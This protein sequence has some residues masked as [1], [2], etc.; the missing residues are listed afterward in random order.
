MNTKDIS[1]ISLRKQ[2]TKISSTNNAKC[3]SFLKHFSELLTFISQIL[4][5]ECKIQLQNRNISKLSQLRAF[6]PPM[7]HG[8]SNDIDGNVWSFGTDSLKL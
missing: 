8:H 5:T 7:V 2:T 4:T 1:R 6:S 3:I